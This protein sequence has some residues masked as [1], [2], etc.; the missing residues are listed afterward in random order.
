MQI[1]KLDQSH[2][3]SS[4]NLF[5]SNKYMG[6][7]FDQKGW[8]ADAA[9]YNQLTYKIFCDTY[10]SGLKNFHAYGAINDAGEVEAF[11]SIYEAVDEAAWYYTVH[12]NI[13]ETNHIPAIL[14]KIIEIQEQAGR[15]KFY[16]LMTGRH[17]KAMRKFIYSDYNNERYGYI[18]EYTVPAKC[19][20]VYT[21]AWEIL[22]K[23]F[24]IPVDTIVR[25]SYLKQ[26]YRKSLPL[27]GAI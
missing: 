18:D 10:L 17:S 23:R 11:I 16:S 22:F 20:C 5:K 6:V 27:G 19:K 24:L 12:R 13:G 1:M 7:T 3:Q 21:N 26:E 25:C 9:A 15:L 2:R 4:E 14:D 8:A